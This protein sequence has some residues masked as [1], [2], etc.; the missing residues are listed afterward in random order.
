MTKSGTTEYQ[1]KQILG[2]KAVIKGLSLEKK[3]GE[4][5]SKKGYQISYEKP[6]GGGS[7][8]RFDVFGKREY[9]FEE[10]EYCVVECKNKAR[11][12]ATDV[13]HFMTKVRVL[14]RRLPEDSS[15][16]VILAYTGEL[17]TDAKGAASGFKPRIKF[18]KM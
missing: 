7:K 5:L 15:L 14:Y 10:P 18:Q 12:T 2:H 1:K 17:P 11:V 9:D 16:T 3:M 6:V 8:D 4:V 13:L